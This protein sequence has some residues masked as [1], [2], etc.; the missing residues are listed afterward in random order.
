CPTHASFYSARAH[1][2]RRAEVVRC[3]R[4]NA[5]SE[6]HRAN[7]SGDSP[8]RAQPGNVTEHTADVRN[9]DGDRWLRAWLVIGELGGPADQDRRQ[10]SSSG[11]PWR[12]T[13]NPPSVDPRALRSTPIAGSAPT[14]LARQLGAAA[15]RAR[16]RRAG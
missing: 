13:G 10:S 14:R 8:I 16:A 2:P 15:R 11:E 9:V 6:L 12:H 4:R 5:A 1:S 7:R 3:E